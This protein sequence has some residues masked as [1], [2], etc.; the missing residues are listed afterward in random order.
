MPK[1]EQK[2]LKIFHILRG[3]NDAEIKEFIANNKDML[4]SYLLIFDELSADLAAFVDSCGIDCIKRKWL[5]LQFSKLAKAQNPSQR[6]SATIPPVDS[7]NAQNSLFKDSAKIPRDST[8]S[9]DS[10][11]SARDSAKDSTHSALKTKFISKLIRSGENVANSGDIAIFNRV[12]SASK[13]IS[14]GNI[15]IFGECEGDVECNGD[16]LVLG[17]ITKGKII[18]Q[19]DIITQAMLKYKLNVVFRDN[20]ALKI[21]DILSL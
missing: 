19:G 3:S 2:N 18:F 17:K 12:N 4:K 7:T 8:K 11:E 13:I 16:F 21:K 9:H 5:S 15:M 10:T 14:D 20:G 6:D 1:F